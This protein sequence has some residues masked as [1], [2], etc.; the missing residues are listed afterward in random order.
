M[1]HTLEFIKNWKVV[2][3]YVGRVLY[4]SEFD[5]E[6]RKRDLKQKHFHKVYIILF[7]FKFIYRFLYSIIKDTDTEKER[8]LSRIKFSSLKRRDTTTKQK[9]ESQ[10]HSIY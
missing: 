2:K 7:K 4:I 6:C 3:L 1:D 9:Y 10:V 5:K 8:R